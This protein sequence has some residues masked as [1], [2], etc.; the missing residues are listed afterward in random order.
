MHYFSYRAERVSVGATSLGTPMQVIEV[1]S[2]TGYLDIGLVT[3]RNPITFNT[4]VQ[5]IS[6]FSPNH[7]IEVNT[8][9]TLLGWGFLN[10]T[11][12]SNGRLQSVQMEILE[13][14]K[15]AELIGN[16]GPKVRD[17]NLC[18]VPVQGKGGCYGDGVLISEGKLV[19][20]SMWYDCGDGRPDIYAKVPYFHSW[21][22]QNTKT[23][24]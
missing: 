5:P 20:I 3:L 11:L 22:E 9:V 15:C 13:N 6:M 7:P 17:Y 8:P 14:S 12:E 2:Q 10:R 24:M 21:I 1:K 19:G 23:L 18:T 16:W 4:L